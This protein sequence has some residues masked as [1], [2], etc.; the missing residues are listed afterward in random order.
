[1]AANGGHVLIIS[2]TWLWDPSVQRSRV[3]WRTYD[4][5][6]GTSECPA[7]E[8]LLAEQLRLDREALEADLA[9]IFA[10]QAS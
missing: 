7:R 10:R 3:D 9:G 8:R 6:C 2:R 1:M 5:A 4:C